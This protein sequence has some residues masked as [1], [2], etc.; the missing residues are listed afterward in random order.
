MF[1]LW[2]DVH[3]ALLQ[4]KTTTLRQGLPS[5][6]ALFFN[7]PVRG[8]VPVMDRPPINT[9]NDEEHH[10]AL[11]NRQWRNYWGNDTFKNF[12]SLPIGSTVAFQWECGGPWTHGTIEDK[13]DHNHHDRSFN[14]CITKTRRII[15]SNRQHIR[16]TPIS[17]EYYLCNELNKHTKTDPL[18]TIL[19]HLEKHPPPPTITDTSNER[20]H[21]NNNSNKLTAPDNVQNNNEK[22]MEEKDTNIAPNSKYSNDKENVIR[23]RYGRIVKKLDRLTY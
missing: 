21:S 2:G 15:T 3:I 11:T 1:W 14:I 13:G 18:D 23:T 7:H 6:A 19:G 17:A 22:Q 9:D 20:P 12:V 4:I 8:I 10:K 5:L 16:L